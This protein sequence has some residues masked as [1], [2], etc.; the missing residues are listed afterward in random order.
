MTKYEPHESV[1]P[2]LAAIR[3]AEQRHV[4]AIRG[5][6]PDTG[7]SPMFESL[8]PGDRGWRSP[9]GGFAQPA[10]QSKMKSR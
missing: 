7:R 6:D 9:L 10:Q 5:R 3:R 4:N 1:R 8:Q 2:L